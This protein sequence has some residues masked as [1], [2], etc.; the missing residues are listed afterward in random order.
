M[1]YMFLIMETEGAIDGLT[2]EQR[3]SLYETHFVLSAKMDEAGVKRD[4]RPLRPPTTATTVRSTDGA[5][6]LVSD[7]PYAE[8]KEHLG[9]Y[10]LVEVADLDEALHW[11]RQ[12]PLPAGLSV[13]VRPVLPTGGA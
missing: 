10:Y 9:G 12:I 2:D 7:G 4:G 5:D 3:R 1:E 11:A 6:R 13:E 8:T